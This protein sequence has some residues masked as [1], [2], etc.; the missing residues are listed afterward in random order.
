MRPKTLLRTLGTALLCAS[1]AVAGGP[2][3]APAGG[4][5]CAPAWTPP[6]CATPYTSP[7]AP[8]TQTPSSQLPGGLQPGAQ[9]PG[10]D[11]QPATDAFA[12]AP[13]SGGE[14]AQSAAPNMIGDLGFYGVAPRSFVPQNTIVTKNTVIPGLTLAQINQRFNLSPSFPTP[15]FNGPYF[16]LNN[17]Q[18][19]TA[20]QLNALT[21]STVI[22]Q[23]VSQPSSQSSSQLSNRT[24]VT[25]FGAFKISENESVSPT[26]RVFA[27]YNYYNVDGLHGNSSSINREVI[28]FEKTFLDGRASFGVRAPYTEVGDGLGGSSDFD[29]L[30]LIFKY[31]F[32]Q[33]RETG[34]TLTGGLVV[35]VPTGP[36]ISLGFGSPVDPTLLQPYV[37]YCLNFGR[38][39]VEGFSEIIVPTDTRLSTF[40]GND[41]GVGYRLEAIPV[42]PIF[43]VHSNN[44]LNHQGSDAS[45]LGFVDSVILTGGF[46]TLIGNSVLTLG[47]A[48][49][50]TGPRL[51]S[52]EAVV[53]FNWHF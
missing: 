52:V 10:A 26:D 41:I 38:F 33:N 20:A 4:P 30:S 23:S 5:G 36:D 35:T 11:Q 25:S 39:Y 7:A 32:F 51:N 6:S 37:G 45:P 46:H 43:E 1:P 40:V 21:R 44:A 53:Q 50:I 47:A 18:Q 8:G 9:Q 16:D 42:I 28:G 15:G 19:F 3:V 31:A 49:P 34:T 22:S 17:S 29:S 13:P 27:T 14:T 12:Q 24:P 2:V 48:T